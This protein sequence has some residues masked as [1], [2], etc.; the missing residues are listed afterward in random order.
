MQELD[1]LKVAVFAHVRT[2]YY[3]AVD[4]LIKGGMMGFEEISYDFSA[5]VVRKIQAGKYPDHDGK[6]A[7]WVA[8]CWPRY[9]SSYKQAFYK[10]QKDLV[11][12]HTF[13]VRDKDKDVESKWKIGYVDIR[14]VEEQQ[15]KR[16]NAGPYLKHTGYDNSP[17]QRVEAIMRDLDDPTTRFGQLDADM[18]AI[19]RELWKGKSVTEVG[20]S[21]GLCRRQVDRKL[22]ALRE[23]KL[24]PFLHVS[25]NYLMHTDDVV[26]GGRL[27]TVRVEDFERGVAR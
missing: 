11:G 17:K 6:L 5:H 27:Y 22:K 24:H 10:E 2:G 23:R 21:V 19:I 26:K 4:D 7:N 3:K 14:N 9:C 8:K 12:V 16:E 15:Y 13:E 1:N 18:K 25:P 20:K